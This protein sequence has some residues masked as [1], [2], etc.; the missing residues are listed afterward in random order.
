MGL[1]LKR[2]FRVGLAVLVGDQA[3]NVIGSGPLFEATIIASLAASGRY[4]RH[5]F[6]QRLWTRF[7][8]F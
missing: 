4:L 6:P 7:L 3:A 8:P 2:L 5:R 1:A